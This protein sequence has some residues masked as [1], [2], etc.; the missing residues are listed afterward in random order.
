M[1]QKGEVE[2]GHATKAAAQTLLA[3]LYLNWQV[4]TGTSPEFTDGTQR[5]SEVIA[6]CND[7]IN[8]GKYKL[9]DDWR[10]LFSADNAK[11]GDQTETIFP[12]INDIKAGVSGDSWM[13]NVL[14][15]NQ[16]F[17]PYTRLNNGFCTTPEFLA[18]WDPTDPRYSDDR[19]K[20]QTGFNLGFL[21][22][23][24][25]DV[26]GNELKTRQ[27][28]TLN[29]TR[30]FPLYDCPE[31]G[32]VRVVKYAPN[33]NATSS[34]SSDNDVQYYRLT[35]IYLMRAE[36]KMRSGDKTGALEDLNTIRRTRGVKE[37]SAAEFTLDKIY[38]ERGYEFYWEVGENRRMDMIRFGHFFEARTTKP[39]VTESY[40]YVFP[41]PEEA[42]QGNP[43]LKQNAGYK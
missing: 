6:L 30:D 31:N 3:K 43:N 23:V 37:V 4:F 19:M 18:T 2:Y 12:L 35:D 13:S 17:G 29:Y 41:I 16:T 39:N 32:G 11:Y 21:E 5:W 14:H 26:N 38:N 8:S 24:Q 20:A 10:E 33:M 9:A 42:L 25:Y 40:K 28:E 7:I 1:K 22:G 34:S 15:Y 36:A 27:G